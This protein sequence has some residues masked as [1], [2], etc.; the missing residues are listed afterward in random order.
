M[1]EGHEIAA[2][3]IEQLSVIGCDP[4]DRV[5]VEARLAKAV[6]NLTE[7]VVD[8][9]NLTVVELR[10][11]LDRLRVS[12]IRLPEQA[13]FFAVVARVGF[14]RIRVALEEIVLGR[15][16]VRRVGLD[17]EQKQEKW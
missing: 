16:I 7:P 14:V 12:Q 4:H 17:V 3:R 5:L 6:D 10:E 13:S 2:M 11:P 1:V 8:E 9:M 15:W